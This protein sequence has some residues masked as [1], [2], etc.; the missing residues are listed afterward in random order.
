VGSTGGGL[1]II[2]STFAL[3]RLLETVAA[4]TPSATVAPTITGVITDP[5]AV[6]VAAAPPAV[7]TANELPEKH[8]AADAAIRIFFMMLTLDNKKIDLNILVE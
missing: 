3:P 7:S 8:K 6:E 4:T 5:T 1:I 2:S